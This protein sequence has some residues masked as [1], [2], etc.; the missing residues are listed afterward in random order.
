V[1][2]TC[3]S[4]DERYY[5]ERAFHHKVIIEQDVLSDSKE[6][7]F[8][9]LLASTEQE[10]KQ[11]CQQNPIS[12]VHWLERDKLGKL[13]GQ[14]SQ[15]S[16]ETLRKYIDTS[17]S[18]TYKADDLDKLMEQAYKNRVMLISDTAGM[19]KSTV[20]T[21]L[22]KRIK[23]KFP[24]KW[25]VRIDLND[26]TD[27]F[28]ALKK[29][30]IDKESEVEF[31][32][33]ELLK[34]KPGLEVQLFKQCCEQK[35]KVNIVIMLDG[36]D[37]ISPYYKQTVIALLQALRQTAV[38]QL[39]RPGI[40]QVSHDGKLHFIHR[41]FA[42]YYD[43]DILVNRLTRG[44]KASEQVQDLLLQRIFLEENYWVFRGFIDG[45]LSRFEPSQKVLKQYGN[46]IHDLQRVGEIIL[47]QAAQEDN[48]HIIGFL[49]DSLQA[50]EHT[51]TVHELLLGKDYYRHTAWHLAAVGGHIEILEKIN[52]VC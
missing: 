5:I 16:L 30:Q 33:K 29:G 49:L 52:G 31:V 25:L 19:G 37:E 44:S 11:L 43:A 4:Y 34:L 39:T 2:S 14:Q 27:A 1:S 13:V 28:E 50:G 45:L 26:H 51:D 21:H 12:N 40:V 3:D 23:Q 9:D 6:K 18:H 20:L 32:S 35:Q 48:A 7:K 17:S 47:H 36:F 15:G 22:S 41:T 46:R 8:P 38:E 24:A 10:F 42:E